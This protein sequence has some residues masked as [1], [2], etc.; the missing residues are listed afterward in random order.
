MVNLIFIFGVEKSDDEIRCYLSTALLQFFVL[1]TWF[2]MSANAYNMYA[3][4]THVRRLYSA[5]CVF[6]M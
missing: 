4:V 5:R 6:L 3:A 1:T 2:W